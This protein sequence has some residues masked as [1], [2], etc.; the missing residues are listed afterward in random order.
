MGH[1]CIDVGSVALDGF[2]FALQILRDGA[3]ELWMRNP[4]RRPRQGRLEA[5]T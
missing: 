5:A 1:V 2:A 4:M 3:C